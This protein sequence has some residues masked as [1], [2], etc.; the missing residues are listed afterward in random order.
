MC[1]M[2]I[3]KARQRMERTELRS[4][5]YNEAERLGSLRGAAIAIVDYVYSFVSV[6]DNVNAPYFEHCTDWVLRP[7]NWIALKFVR[8]HGCK[9]H[10]SV[11]MPT[12]NARNDLSVT[13]GRFP[14]WKKFTITSAQQIPSVMLYLE[15]A[16]YGSQN[17]WRRWRGKPK[18][19]PNEAKA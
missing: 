1:A 11:S 15:E 17:E 16:Y 6:D 5:I 19:A 3:N 9:I 13:D 14:G 7:D 4:K 10:V 8:R 2:L 12:L 18:V